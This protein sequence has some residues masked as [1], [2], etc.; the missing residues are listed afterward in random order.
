MQT[1]TTFKLLGATLISLMLAACGGGDGSALDNAL[2][3]GSASSGSG[4]NTSGS[5]SSAVDTTSAKKMGFGESTSFLEGVI[6]SN[7]SALA[8]SAG[9]TVLLTVN[10]VSSTNNLVTSPAEITFN[11]P[12]IASGE[13]VLK[14]G[15]TTTNKVTANNGSASIVY[16][17]NGCVGDDLIT[18]SA[19]IDGGIKNATVKLTV[20]ADT[21]Q[22]MKFIDASPTKISLKGVGGNETA[23][24]R[25]QVVGNTSAPIKGVDVAFALST[26]IGGMQLTNTTAKTDKSGYATTTIQAGTIHTAVRITASAGNIF[27][28]SDPITISTGIPDQKSTSLSASDHFPIGWDIDGAESSIQIRLGDA[29][30]NPPPQGTAVAFTTEGGSIID[31]CITDISGACTVKWTS[32]NPRP[33]RNSS[34]N[35]VDR[36]LCVDSNGDWVNDYDACAIERAG[37]VTVLATS[38]GNESFIDTNGNGYFDPNDQFYNASKTGNCAPNVPI[39]SANTPANSSTIPCD[40]LG[41]AY[42]DK[43]E[44]KTRTSNEEFIDFTSIGTEGVPDNAFTDGNGIYNGALCTAEGVLSKICT[45]NQVTIRRDLLLIMT[46]RYIMKRNGVLPFIN[47]LL[48]GVSPSTSFI[49]ADI[50]GHGAGAG[51]TLSIDGSNLTDGTAGLTFTGPLLGSEDPMWIGVSV[52]P[53]PDK[54]PTG[55][56]NIIVTTKTVVGDI[57]TTQTVLVNPPE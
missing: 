53:S 3:G 14:V 6:G 27:T 30:N 18:A 15:V 4:T 34:D 2:A 16:T 55:S 42:L 31:R 56:F 43:D 29:F 38:T 52:K 28:T 9:G 5:A 40:D 20:E 17:A 26:T 36:R 57:S 47:P 35:S 45:K 48:K 33:T 50:N 8:L 49:L 25:F 13:A 11:S 51:T 22:S 1:K 44:S 54:V 24:V 21:I 10:I 12:C 32:Q 19:P 46:S 23:T 41:E 37:R 7:N 39:L